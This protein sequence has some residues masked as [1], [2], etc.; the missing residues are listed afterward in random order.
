MM[1]KMLSSFKSGRGLNRRGLIGGAAAVVGAALLKPCCDQVHG[2]DDLLGQDWRVPRGKVTSVFIRRGGR[3]LSEAVVGLD[4]WTIPPGAQVN[5]MLEDGEHP[6]G[7]MLSL[8]H[9]DGARIGII[10][11]REQPERCRIVSEG[12][13]DLFYVGANGILGYI[14]GVTIEHAA[15]ARRGLG[16]AVIADEGGFIMTGE[17]VRVIGFYYGFTAR[18]NGTIRAEG[19]SAR[20]N[21]DA[22]YFAFN[23][24]HLY[25]RRS[26]AM[27]AT[28]QDRNL[29]TGFVAE[30]GGT[31]D[32][33]G[34]VSSYNHLAGFAAITNGTIR[35]LRTIAHHNRYAG[36]LAI[37]GGVIVADDA[38]GRDN[39]GLGTRSDELS[40]VFG[41]NL[42]IQNDLSDM[43]KC[44][45]VP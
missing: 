10:G 14:D 26:K 18:R 37:Q 4:G 9:P 3:T 20:D 19:T 34:A 28:D 45:L 33:E 17:R 2:A 8:R 36:Y 42:M 7:A 1:Y 11:N 29:G 38:V 39:C 41:S 40:R 25:V 35:A 12:S 23:G 16:S 31:I 27:N 15:P 32:A 21:G 6:I 44:N 13:H 24:G 22:S 30:Y 5:L 43:I